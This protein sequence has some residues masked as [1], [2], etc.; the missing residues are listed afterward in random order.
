MIAE[1]SPELQKAYDELAHLS[2]DEETRKRYDSV[3]KA[4]RDE[5]SRLEGAE[6]KGIEKGIGEGERRK[7]IEIAKGMLEDGVG[8]DIIIKYTNLDIDMINKIQE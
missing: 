6:K 8:V 4:R 3:I 7:A 1:R 2:Q 5:I